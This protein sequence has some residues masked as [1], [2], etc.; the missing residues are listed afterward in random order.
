MI[1]RVSEL[2]LIIQ[3]SRTIKEYGEEQELYQMAG[4]CL[5]LSV[6]RRGGSVVV[7]DTQNHCGMH[8][9]RPVSHIA[10]GQGGSNI[11]VGGNRFNIAARKIQVT[12]ATMPG[13]SGTVVRVA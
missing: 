12:A 4:G 9:Y 2:S 13:W 5:N 6:R 11:P 8:G 7:Q 1:F 10:L 3:N